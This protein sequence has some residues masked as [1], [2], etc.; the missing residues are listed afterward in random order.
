MLNFSSIW[1]SQGNGGSDVLPVL[2][3]SYHYLHP[4]LKKCFA[5]CAIFPQGYLFRKKS[6][7]RLWMAEGFIK[8]S[9]EGE[10]MEMIGAKYFRELVSGSLFQWSSYHHSFVMH[11]HIHEVAESV[12]GE[13]CFRLEDHAEKCKLCQKTARARHLSYNCGIKKFE[14]FHGGESLRTFLPLP[15]YLPYGESSETNN[16]HLNWLPKLRVLSLNGYYIT[17]LPHSIGDLKHLRY[18]DLSMTGIT[19]L[20]KEVCLLYN[21]Q[22]LI[23]KDCS[24]LERLP[25]K[26]GNLTYLRYLK[27]TSALLEGMPAGL[28]ELKSFKH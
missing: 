26:I 8:E 3:L 12:A 27:I 22:T 19:C 23:L 14:A 11:D 7:V 21:L 2:R 9:Q 24:R 16:V 1:S 6:L 5:Y 17:K 28:K 10:E 20:P 15:R 13:T 25:S 18:L 4:E